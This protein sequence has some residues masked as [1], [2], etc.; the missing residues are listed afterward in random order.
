[1]QVECLKT[2]LVLFAV[3]TIYDG[4][5][6]IS[7]KAGLMVYYLGPVDDALEKAEELDAVQENGI[8]LI[9]GMMMPESINRLGSDPRLRDFLNWFFNIPL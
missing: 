1:M 9:D 5:W 2:G 4:V 3:S 6:S 8:V 7:A